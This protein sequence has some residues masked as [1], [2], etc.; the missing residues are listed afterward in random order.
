MNSSAAFT[1][2]HDQLDV[3]YYQY[4]SV[5]AS[6]IVGLVFA[7]FSL[8]SLVFS[9]LLFVPLTGLFIG[10][11]AVRKIRKYEDELT[12]MG[13]AKTAVLL[14]AVVFFGA[15]AYLLDP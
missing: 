2:S 3:D 8:S 6:A 5:C 11:H 1:D 13:L 9:I 7:F 14:N 10:L 4:K 12:G 15:I